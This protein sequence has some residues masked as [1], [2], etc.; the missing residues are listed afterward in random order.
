MI[1]LIRQFFCKHEGLNLAFDIDEIVDKTT[2]IKCKKCGKK[3][4]IHIVTYGVFDDMYQKGG[5][6]KKRYKTKK[7][8]ETVFNSCLLKKRKKQPTS[9]YFC[10]YC[11]SFHLTSK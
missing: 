3:F 10:N 1:K 7:D 4:Q 11:Q 9:I 6:Q 2:L 8:A 5:C